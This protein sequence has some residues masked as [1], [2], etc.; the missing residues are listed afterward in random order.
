MITERVVMV[1][2]K[3]STSEG[4]MAERRALAI[5]GQKLAA[6]CYK[7]ADAARDLNGFTVAINYQRLAALYSRDVR[8]I[9]G[10]EE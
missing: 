10:I 1:P 7:M 8:M 9:M 3:Y 4:S 2:G 6:Q 5:E